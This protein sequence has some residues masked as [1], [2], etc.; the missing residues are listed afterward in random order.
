MEGFK[1]KKLFNPTM[2]DFTFEY[3]SAPYTVKAGQSE[4]FVDYIAIHGA[5]K[6]ADKEAMTSDPDERKVLGHAYLE[7]S[8]PEVI[9]KNLG[10]NLDKIRKEAMTKEKEKARVINLE[11]QVAEQNKKIDALMEVVSKKEEVK[12][13]KIDKRT[14]TYKESIENDNK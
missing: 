11:A 13:E 3:N 8:D 9:A 10:I 14:K 2:E 12:E 1:L 4:D 6:L 7:N 5:K